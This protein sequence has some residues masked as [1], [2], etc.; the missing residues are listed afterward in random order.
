MVPPKAKA[1]DIV[2]FTSCSTALF[3]TRFISQSGSFS[4]KFT[5]GEIVRFD[6]SSIDTILLGVTVG[7]YIDRTS[8]FVL[9]SGDNIQ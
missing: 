5:V 1:L 2:Y 3:T 7:N 8:N 9:D 4:V 6:E